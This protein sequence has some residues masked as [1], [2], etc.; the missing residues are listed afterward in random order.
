MD[1][2]N[3]KPASG[4]VKRRKR[5]GRGQGSGYGGTSGRGHKGQRSRSGSKIK[6]WFEGGQ[7]PLQR[8]L[9]KRGFTN[10]FK[11]EY[12]IVNLKQLERI[13][14]ATEINPDVLFEAGLIDKRDAAVK[15]LGDGDVGKALTVSAHAF[16]A[17]AQ[18]KIEKAGGK[19]NKL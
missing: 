12:Q 6:P 14:K 16:S 8:R 4:A 7:M 2:G 10:I 13:K 17:S 11:K 5:I 9:P 15:I 19:V 18:E 3:L 1:L